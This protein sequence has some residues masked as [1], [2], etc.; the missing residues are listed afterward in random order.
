MNFPIGYT[1]QQVNAEGKVRITH[2]ESGLHF[3]CRKVNDGFIRINMYDK[4]TALDSHL[5]QTTFTPRNL[6][7]RIEKLYLEIYNQ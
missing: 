7:R 2:L 1:F 3:D 5:V 6:T 4:E